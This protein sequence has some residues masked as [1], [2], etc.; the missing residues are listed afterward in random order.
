MNNENLMQK[1]KILLVD[2]HQIVIDGLRSILETQEQFEI[3][4]EANN[5]KV[6]LQ[7]ARVLSPEIIVMDIDM[8][9]MNGMVASQEFK[10]IHPE[11]KIIILSLHYEKSII[12][13]LVKLGVEGYLLKNSSKEEVINAVQTVQNG[14]KYF[15]TDVTMVLAQPNEIIIPDQTQNKNV[16]LS[17]LTEREIEV[18][19]QIAEGFSNKEIA[20]QLF[21]SPRTVDTH[22]QNIM[23]KLNVN[24]V[25]GLIKFALKNGLA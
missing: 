21:L 17:L 23:K 13:H 20:E 16:M 1:T 10:K 7:I 8:P 2:D 12:Q 5:G 15:S 9:V 3:C 14:K 11:T 24:K 4:C 6:A 22:R 18:L 25:V 19:K